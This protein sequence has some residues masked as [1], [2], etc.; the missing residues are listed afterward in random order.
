MKLTT[1][2]AAGAFALTMPFA[3]S[4]AT[5]DN[6]DGFETDT[7]GGNGSVITTGGGAFDCAFTLTG[8]N[9]GSGDSV[10]TTF[11]A[12]ADGIVS[13]TGFWNYS[14]DDVDGSGLD[15]FG[16]FI[17]DTPFQL[18][19]DGNAAP[20]FENGEFA[21]IVPNGSLFGW[22]ILATDDMLGA[23]DADVFANFEVAA[24]PLPASA[25][26]MLGGLG[27][28]IALRRKATS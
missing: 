20:G 24:V 16:Y 22:Y 1:L 27:G 3:A 14:T 10:P 28:L 12:I 4:A 9:T 19:T 8:S 26:L 2:V 13:V 6:C 17:D 5:Y 11:S 15:Q 25:L 7:F 18:S 21:F 23:A